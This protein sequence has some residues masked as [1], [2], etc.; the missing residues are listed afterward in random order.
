MAIQKFHH[1]IVKR[2][3][4]LHVLNKLTYS[5]K[6]MTDY[7]YEIVRS[8]YGL[9][10]SVLTTGEHM[11]TGLTEDACRWC[12]DNIHIPVLKGTYE[13]YTSIARSATV[14]GKL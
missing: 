2:H 14:E 7:T 8:R 1:Q 4:L 12:T 13:G 11:V 9:Y 10:T 3:V 6:P 5:K